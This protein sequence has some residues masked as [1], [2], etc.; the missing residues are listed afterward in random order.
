MVSLVVLSSYF[1][2]IMFKYSQ[3]VSFVWLVGK[4][5]NSWE[6]QL[7]I[8]YFAWICWMYKI[9]MW[10]ISESQTIASQRILMNLS[11]SMLCQKQIFANMIWNWTVSKCKI[12][13]ERLL[14]RC[15]ELVSVSKDN[16]K[17]TEKVIKRNQCLH[18]R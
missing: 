11:I 4:H 1:S 9:Q 15:L 3:I 6:M 13:I 10:L 16:K 17:T 14:F 18:Q 7:M 12:R 5:I 8:L 2:V